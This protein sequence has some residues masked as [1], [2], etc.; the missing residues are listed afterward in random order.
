MQAETIR[1]QIDKV[2]IRELISE[3]LIEYANAYPH[4]V[5]V[6]KI[7]KPTKLFYQVLAEDLH[8]LKGKK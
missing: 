8:K 3:G 7:F 1:E 2:V 5:C 4:F 6:K